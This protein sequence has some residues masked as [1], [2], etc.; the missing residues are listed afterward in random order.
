MT[1]GK[2]SS[3]KVG[4]GAAIIAVG[5]VAIASLVPFGF[6]V[7]VSFRPTLTGPAGS[8][9][10]DLFSRVPV[11]Q[12]MLNSAIVSITSTVLVIVISTM[13]GYGFAK[14]PFPGRRGAFFLVIAAISVPFATTVLPNYLNIARLGGV[15]QYWSPILLYTAGSLPFAII[16]TASFF[17][18]LPDE[19]IESALMDGAS[20]GRIFLSIMA[21]LAVPAAVT[22]GVISFLGSWNDL[23]TGLLLLPDPDMRTISVGVAALQGVRNSNLDLVLTGSLV[24][25]I[26]PVVAFIVFQKYLVSG[27]T[28]GVSR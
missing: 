10:V 12:Y 23:L 27:I 6:L 26:P 17:R 9:W 28:A 16:L 18:S 3:S 8:L 13:A 21:P 15:G 7:A 2:S 1:R 11:G 4:R 5:L 22:V 25:A 19:L 14:L 20:Y 24:S